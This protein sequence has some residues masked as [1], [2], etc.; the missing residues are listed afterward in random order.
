MH[1]MKHFSVY[2]SVNNQIIVNY[3][4]IEF[5]KKNYNNYQIVKVKLKWAI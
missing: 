2:I 4:Y 3:L 1:T 5:L